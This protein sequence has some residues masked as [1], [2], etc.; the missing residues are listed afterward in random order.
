MALMQ[1]RD[2]Q[3]SEASLAEKLSRLGMSV[4]RV[5]MGPFR[6]RL[7]D[8]YA[9]YRGKYGDEAWA[10]LEASVGKLG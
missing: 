3:I 5:D 10:A 9:K 4:N 2:M 1:R 6:A 8:F 7:G